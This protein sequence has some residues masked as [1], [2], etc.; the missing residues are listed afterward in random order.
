[1]EDIRV[2]LML[3]IILFIYIVIIRIFM[4]IANA[5]GERLG[6]GR[7][8]ITLFRKMFNGSN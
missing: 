7:F 4:R 2:G 8:V 3:L 5:I 1:M 6:V